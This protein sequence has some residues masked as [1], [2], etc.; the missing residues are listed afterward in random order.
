MIFFTADLHIGH[1]NIIKLCQRPFA[2]LEEMDETLISNWNHVVTN[3]DTVYIIGDLM[4]RTQAHPVN[5]LKR[6]KGK[7]HLIV[8]NHDKTWLNKISADDYF[9]SIE[10]YSEI[11]DG[12]RKLALCHY[13]MMSWGGI[14]KGSCLVHGH[15]HNNRDAAYWPLLASMDQALNASVEINQYQPVSFEQLQLNNELFK[16]GP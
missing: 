8:G 11:S 5:V 2:S 10:R 9:K 1:K 7:K 16:A 6:L 13:P 12:K 14:G 15:I 3:G 4:F